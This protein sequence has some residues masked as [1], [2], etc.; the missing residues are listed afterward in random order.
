MLIGCVSIERGRP[1]FTKSEVGIHQTLNIVHFCPHLTQSS[2]AAQ[3]SF[4][5]VP[6]YHHSLL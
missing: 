4:I 1:A 6:L 5:D 2:L 3:T